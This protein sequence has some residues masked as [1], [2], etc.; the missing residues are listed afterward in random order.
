MRSVW[1]LASTGQVVTQPDMSRDVWLPVAPTCS[2]N[3]PVRTEWTRIA[4]ART[5]HRTW[6]PGTGHW[7]SDTGRADTG[8]AD[9]GHR[10][11]GRWTR[12]RWTRTGRR[13][14]DGRT[15]DMRT[16]T[17]RPRRGGRPDILVPRHRWTANRAAV[18][19]AAHAALGNHDGSA[20]RPPASARGCGLHCQASCWVA[21]PAAKRRLGALLS[22]DD[23]GSRVER[24]ALGQVL[25]RAGLQG[26]GNVSGATVVNW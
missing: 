1:R 4:D 22:S 9:T 23:F 18:A 25:W 24:Q 12:G 8:R 6:T 20:V 19:A 5:G 11:R 17:G 21:P 3:S 14:L 2:T 7:T 10:T 16:R 13:T 26:V 15:L